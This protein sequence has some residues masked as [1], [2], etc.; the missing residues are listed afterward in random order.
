MTRNLYPKHA[1]ISIL[2]IFSTLA[3]MLSSCSAISE[4]S[5]STVGV[6]YDLTPTK[7][8]PATQELTLVPPTEIPT[9]NL[10]PEPTL[11]QTLEPTVAETQVIELENTI[12]SECLLPRAIQK[13]YE[14]VYEGITV[15][16]SFAIDKTMLN[17]FV[18]TIV[19]FDLNIKDY[20]E[21]PELIAL[22][23]LKI[24]YL[25]WKFDNPNSLAD[26][27]DYI[28]MVKNGGG[29]YTTIA[30]VDDL[31]ISKAK[32][33]ELK[34][35]I[36]DPKNRVTYIESMDPNIL[37]QNQNESIWPVQTLSGDF[38]IRRTGVRLP[39]NN[40]VLI[41]YP[42]HSLGRMWMF[43]YLNNAIGHFIGADDI[44]LARTG[45][46]PSIGIPSQIIQEQ[47]KIIIDFFNNE[48][49]KITSP[50]YFNIDFRK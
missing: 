12:C 46:W 41:D 27:D 47:S 11:I 20:P 25:G 39:G 15:K 28:E 34:F 48:R 10:T 6:N 45:I 43:K 14:G 37:A 8:D 29:Q 33:S 35:V 16:F 26:F 38:E 2:F 49:G 44:D 40:Q 24:H 9:L 13:D 50:P 22:D 18:G 5:I 30:S 42:A 32:R 7:K 4:T 3:G 1:I 31:S 17:H 19:D 23:T 21:L 36:V